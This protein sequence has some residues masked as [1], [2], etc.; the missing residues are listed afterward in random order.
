MVDFKLLKWDG[1]FKLPK[2][3]KVSIY[4]SGMG[5]FFVFLYLVSHVHI[6]FSSF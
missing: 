5:L 6:F 3:D 4:Q 2:W 1:G